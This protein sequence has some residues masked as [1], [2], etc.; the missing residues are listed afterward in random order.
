MK[1]LLIATHNKAKKEEILRGLN[2]LIKEGIKIVDLEE[3]HISMEPEET[4]KTFQENSLLKAKFYAELSQLP[5]IADDG[6]L[7]IPFLNNEPG[8]KSR[9]W[10]GYEVTDEELIKYALSQL[11]DVKGTNRIAFLETCLCFYDPLSRQTNFEQEKIKGRISETPLTIDTN[12]YPFRVLFIVEKYNK[13]YDE[14]T[15]EE[16]EKENHRLK[17]LKRLV[18]KIMPNLLQ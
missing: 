15:K 7:V 3:L 13:F 17:A 18:K 12:G 11:K 8:V 14:L 9:R 4:G 1:K 5:T 10:P 6:G 2:T 16:H